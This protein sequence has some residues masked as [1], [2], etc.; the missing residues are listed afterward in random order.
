[1]LWHA[2][3][4]AAAGSAI[5]HSPRARRARKKS[6]VV[7]TYAWH[8]LLV[9]KMRCSNHSGH[10]SWCPLNTFLVESVIGGIRF[11]NKEDST[12]TVSVDRT[13]EGLY[14]C[15]CEDVREAPSGEWAAAGSSISRQL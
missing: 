15:N 10:I 11:L 13:Q 7:Q 2:G 1:M 4:Y 6:M 12:R 5:R 14:V 3:T 8:R 9:S